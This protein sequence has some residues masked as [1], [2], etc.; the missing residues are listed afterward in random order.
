M[1]GDGGFQPGMAPQRVDSWRQAS[2][3]KRGFFGGSKFEVMGKFALLVLALAAYAMTG[4]S[5]GSSIG[6]ELDQASVSTAR[7]SPSRRRSRRR[8]PRRSAAAR[9]CD[10]WA[11]VGWPRGRS[12]ATHLVPS[13][14]AL[15]SVV[16]GSLQC[17]YHARR[18]VGPVDAASSNFEIHRLVPFVRAVMLSRTRVWLAKRPRLSPPSRFAS[19]E[20]RSS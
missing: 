18:R 19:T 11:R 12:R 20:V 15:F 7:L 1:R 2:R 3:W 8:R 10:R 13:Q 16:C 5:G 9:R 4:P 17:Q 6:A 14:V